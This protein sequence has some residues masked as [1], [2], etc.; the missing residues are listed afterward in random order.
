M[1]WGKVWCKV[2]KDGVYSKTRIVAISG[3][4]LIK[5]Q[6]C[7]K[8]NHNLSDTVTSLKPLAE[9]I[10]LARVQRIA[11]Y[12]ANIVAQRRQR[13]IDSGLNPSDYSM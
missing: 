9:E 10:Q 3:G 11:K 2:C 1:A 4:G 13:Y 8:H 12:K 7:S 6:C 5:Y